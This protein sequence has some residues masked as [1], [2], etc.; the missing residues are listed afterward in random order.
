MLPFGAMQQRQKMPRRPHVVRKFHALRR[1]LAGYR[2]RKKRSRW[3]RQWVRC[4]RVISALVPAAR[5]RAR[6]VVVSIFV[7]PAQFAPH[8]DLTTYPRTFDADLAALAREK[9]DLVWAPPV[10]SMY[11]AGFGTRIVP[12]GAATAGLEDAVR[13]HFFAGVATVVGKLL[14]QCLPDLAIFGEKDF[15]QLKVVTQLAKDLDFPVKIVGVPTVR[16]KDGLA[17]SSRNA[18]LSPVQR[19]VAPALYGALKVAARRI[20]AGEPIAR[21]MADGRAELARAGFSVDYFE[22][23]EAETLAPVVSAGK[24]KLRLLAAAE[25]GKTR[26]IDNIKA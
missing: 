22:A 8:E 20:A 7:N 6:R 10:D 13:P 14:I 26:L 21:V 18:Y 9:V 4:T 23:R 17:L 12:E 1:A 25:L 15:Q 24:G 19:A 16:E 2:A 5:R 3:C 11:P